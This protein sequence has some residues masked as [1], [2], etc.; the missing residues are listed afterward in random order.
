MNDNVVYLNGQFVEKANANISILDR[1]FLFGDGVYEVVPAFDGKMLGADEHLQRL[2]NSLDA[3]HLTPPLSIDEWKKVL[4]DLIHKN[5]QTQGK[6]AMYLQVTRG[7][8][9]T[10]SHAIP[11]NI[12]PTVVAFCIPA[13]TTTRAELEKGYAA[14]TLQDTRRKEC[15]IKAITLLPNILLYEQ[16]KKAGAFEAILVRNGEVTECT[17]SNV[18]M[19]KYGKLITP[20]LSKQILGGVTRDLILQLANDNGIP[21]RE[22]TVTEAMLDDADE[23]WITASNKEI[24]PIVTLNGHPVANGHVGPVWKKV[25][26]L[27]EAHKK[28]LS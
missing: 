15:Y 21:T 26:E 11:H 27:Y 2:Q 5:Q 28:E 13:K 16:A 25:I 10:R 23:I 8:D 1:G 12:K 18:F 19:V 3:I 24:C 4:S 6:C 7:A 22:K 20:P 14:V 9:V 17:G